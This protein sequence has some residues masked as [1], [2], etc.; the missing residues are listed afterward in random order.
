MLMPVTSNLDGTY[1]GEGMVNLILGFLLDTYYQA[2][3]N[4]QLLFVKGD[5]NSD[6]WA[7]VLGAYKQLNREKNDA[8]DATEYSIRQSKEKGY[9][10]LTIWVGVSYFKPTEKCMDLELYKYRKDW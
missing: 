4:Q 10:E 5:V 7:P 1:Y 9:I 8:L 3:S 2:E 6:G